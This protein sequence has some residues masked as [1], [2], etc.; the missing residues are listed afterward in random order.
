M[1]ALGMR[2]VAIRQ[3]SSGAIRIYL[4][5]VLQANGTE[6]Q[7]L[8]AS[9]DMRFGSIRTGNNFFNGMLDDIR[10]FG[11]VLTDAEISALA[12]I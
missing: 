7:S 12:G 3:K 1:M 8:D 4:D 11:R 6:T 5:G 10:V 2:C 9:T